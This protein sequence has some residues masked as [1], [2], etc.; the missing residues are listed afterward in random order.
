MCCSK[1]S[2]ENGIFFSRPLY[3]RLRKLLRRRLPASLEGAHAVVV[4]TVLAAVASL[5]LATLSVC[6][7]ACAT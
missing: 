3:M 5:A 7:A 2:R 4:S 6:A 1:R